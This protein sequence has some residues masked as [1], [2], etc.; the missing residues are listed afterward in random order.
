MHVSEQLQ[1]PLELPLAV[2]E[3]AFT[4]AARVTLRRDLATHPLRYISE[5]RVVLNLLVG[6]VSQVAQHG[7]GRRLPSIVLLENLKQFLRSCFIVGFVSAFLNLAVSFAI[8]V[9][10]S[11]I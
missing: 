6:D 9:L 7:Q 3:R 4:S 1:L 10:V 8:C 2:L 5:A 11:A